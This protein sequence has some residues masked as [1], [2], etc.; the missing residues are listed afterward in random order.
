[1]RP[2]YR[3]AIARCYL[4][5]PVIAFLGVFYAGLGAWFQQDDFA[6]LQLAAKTSAAELPAFL[7]KPVAQGTFRPLSERLFYWVIYNWFGLDAFPARVFCF[8]LQGVN[9]I[10]LALLLFR[11][12]GSRWGAALSVTA[13]AVQP[14]LTLPMTWIATTN[15]VMW[16]FCALGTVYLYSRYCQTGS[17]WMLGGAWCLYLAGFGVLETNVTVPALITLYVLAFDRQRWKATLP[18]WVP[19]IAF[20]AAHLLLIPKATQGIYG[21]RVGWDAFSAAWTYWRWTWLLE[22]GAPGG[23]TAGIIAAGLSAVLLARAVTRPFALLGIGWFLAAL[24][25][26][27]ALPGH[28]TDYYLTVPAMGIAFLFLAGWRAYP[29]GTV[30]ALGCYLIANVP[31]AHIY[32]KTN[33]EHSLDM[34]ALVLGVGQAQK[35]HPGKTLLLDGIADSLFWSGV[36]DNPFP[37]VGAGITKLTPESAARLAPLPELFNANDYTLDSAAVS[38]LLSLGQVEVYQLRNRRLSRSTLVY[39]TSPGRGGQASAPRKIELAN[40]AYASFLG[41]EWHPAEGTFRWMPGRSTVTLEGSGGSA[42][43]RGFCV[44]EQLSK[45]TER[46]TVSAKWDDRPLGERHV[47]TCGQEVAVRFSL[48]AD[49]RPKGALSIEVR[50]VRPIGG[51]D[52]ELALAVYSVEIQ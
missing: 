33:T 25:P 37:L 42:I 20:A 14:S 19:A 11:L 41:P 40:F 44:P 5:L 36:Y 7:V 12:T 2:A 8:V 47:T 50:P 15:Q 13:W 23:A 21:V 45:T 10:L 24:A 31:V 34:Q 51:D 38:A 6:H 16:A 17:R 48:P 4:L 18:F 35:L 43:I 29:L 49:R 27:L 22:P 26:V 52:R 46:L 30:L 1:M 9:C 3:Y 39:A 32:S 28:L